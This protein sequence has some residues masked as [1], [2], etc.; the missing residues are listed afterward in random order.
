M[1]VIILVIM[2]ATSIAI[3]KLMKPPPEPQQ[4][5]QTPETAPE[6]KIHRKSNIPHGVR[7]FLFVIAAIAGTII[8]IIVIIIILAMLVFIF[9]GYQE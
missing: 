1:N 4:G 7:R 8:G 9:G 3:I 5:Q 6:G 2:I